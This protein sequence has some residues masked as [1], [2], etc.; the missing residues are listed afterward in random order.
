MFGS[1][2][3]SKCIILSFKRDSCLYTGA[4]AFRTSFCCYLDRVFFESLWR[5]S[6]NPN[7]LHLKCT[8]EYPLNLSILLSG[9]KETNL[10]S[11]SSGERRGKCSYWKS[12]VY[13]WVVVFMHCAGGCWNGKLFWKKAR[14][15]VRV[16]IPFRSADGPLYSSLTL[17]N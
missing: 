8:R 14:F 10:D 16:P 2:C 6:R 13:H 4:I 3:V 15:W 11:L 9:G 5:P 1:K 7:T 17:W 12:M